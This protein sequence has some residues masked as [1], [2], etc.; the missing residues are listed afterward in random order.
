MKKQL[1]LLAVVFCL[2]IFVIVLEAQPVDTGN[3]ALSRNDLSENVGK[4][5]VMILTGNGSGQVD[6]IGSGV[7]LKKD[8]VILTAYH[9]IKGATQV[10]IRLKNGEIFDRVDLLG[11]DERRDV[12][13][14][15]ISA[16][17]LPAALT[18]TSE[19]TIGAKVVVV[20]NPQS[21]GWT[22]TDGVM[23]AVRMSDEV[24]GAGRGYRVLQFTAP[25][26]SGSSGGFLAN[27]TGELLGIIVGSLTSGQ[28]LNFA[29]PID[30]VSGLADS[31]VSMSFGRGNDLELPQ[32][33]RPPVSAD[34]IEAD[35]SKILQ[36]AKFLYVQANSTFIKDKMME[37]ALMKRPEF[38]K[39]K[40]VIVEDIKLADIE[41]VPSHDLFTWDYRYKLI[42]RRTKILLATSKTTA[43]DGNVASERFA[44][45]IIDKLRPGRE[46]IKP[47]P[48][49][50]SAKK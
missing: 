49:G 2:A 39:W 1:V 40:L 9:V 35:P 33:V 15:K 50:T 47:V 6:K 27:E 37:R 30:S 26:S 8:G 18:S 38:A 10:Q 29:V 43:W 25:V 45:S 42:D 36:T 20:S 17:N 24:S 5:A 14:L 32:A 22:F 4:S 16:S 28:N 44:K 23:S 19:P 3:S 46:P 11:F 7:I 13:A 48:A 12:A 41:I 34:L 31:K 21:L